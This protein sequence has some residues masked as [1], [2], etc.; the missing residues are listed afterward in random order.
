MFNVLLRVFTRVA[1]RS[2]VLIFIL[3]VCQILLVL[4]IHLILEV[5]RNVLCFLLRV[6]YLLCIPLLVHVLVFLVIMGSFLRFTWHWLLMIFLE[7]L[8]LSLVLRGLLKFLWRL[9]RSYFLLFMLEIVFLF[10]LLL[11]NILNLHFIYHF[12]GCSSASSS[13]YK[14]DFLLM[15]LLQKFLLV[16]ITLRRFLALIKFLVTFNLHLIVVAVGKRST[17]LNCVLFNWFLVVVGLHFLNIVLLGLL[18]WDHFI[19]LLELNNLVL[20]LVILLLLL[21]RVVVNVFLVLK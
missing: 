9:W 21:R 14:I 13:S 7:F 1:R 3:F 2:H 11:L 12:D 4:A 18:N 6:V 5:R 15:I 16:I 10:V 8:L 17:S 20:L 19:A